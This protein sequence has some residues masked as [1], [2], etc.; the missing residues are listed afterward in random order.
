MR[1]KFIRKICFI[2]AVLLSINVFAKETPDLFLNGELKDVQIILKGSNTLIPLRFCSEELLA[3][4]D[5][6]KKTQEISI[7][8]GNDKVL[9]TVGSLEYKHN[10]K[11]K[12]LLVAPELING[13]TYVPFRPLVEALN[14]VVLYNNENKFINIYDTSSE[15]YKVYKALNSKDLIEQRFAILESPRKNF[16]GS[17]GGNRSDTY[18]F[19][20]GK[21][22]DY[23]FR[24]Y[25]DDTIYGMDYFKIHDGVA[26]EEWSR[27]Q[28]DSKQIP[29]KQSV[30]LNY[31]GEGSNIKERG[32]FPD[33]KETN[34]V[35]FRNI[36]FEASKENIES[37]YTIGN[38][39]SIINKNGFSNPDLNTPNKLVFSPFGSL[40]YLAEFDENIFRVEE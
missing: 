23:F 14:G 24:Y 8:K 20:L 35:G 15:A 9:F 2:F 28:D 34:F 18:I 33:P 26:V 22:S 16:E 37:M 12:E 4:V 5:W 29:L 39:V 38:T 1:K 17:Y 32:V 31:L 40:F 11:V 6:D 36:T 3:T 21:S 30:L 13:I 25:I 7:T 10:E 19:P 27:T